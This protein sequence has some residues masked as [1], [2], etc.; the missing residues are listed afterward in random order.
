MSSA[1]SYPSS[2]DFSTFDRKA[3][4]GENLTVAFLGGSLTWGAQATDPL[5]TSYRALVGKKLIAAYPQAHF[6]FRDAAIGGTGSQLASF[7]LERDVLAHEPDLLFLDFTINDNPY[8]EPSEH[9]LASYEGVV[10]RLVAKGIPI[11]QVVLPAKKDLDANPEARP[12]DPLHKAI[13]SAYGLPLADAVALARRRA[14]EGMT[15]A[16]LLWDLPTDQTHPGD[17]GYALYADAAWEAFQ[18]AV[19]TGTNCRLPERMI[20]DNKYLTVT[21]HVLSQETL[22]AGWRKGVPHRNAVAFDFVCSR[23]MDSLVIA[24]KGAASLKFSVQGADILLFG[25]MTQ[26]SGNFAV[27]IDGG[28]A[29]EYSAKCTD[30]NMR[31]PYVVAEGLDRA[32]EHTVEILPMLGEGEELRIESLCVAGG[33]AS[34]KLL[35]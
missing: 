6:T 13:G 4:D 30:G 33:T 8:V 31:L 17:A 9:R 32:Q 16:D 19:K 20:H 2:L 23:W 3:R 1:A 25:E 18:I 12:L 22:P 7:R 28:E 21:R 34:V 35:A 29:V 24:E 26:K 27:R 5:Q 14:A 10:R 11:V 15:T